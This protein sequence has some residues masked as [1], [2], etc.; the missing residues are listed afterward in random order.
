MNI[1][2]RFFGF[3]KLETNETKLTLLYR[4]MS[5]ECSNRC[6]FGDKCRNKRF[7]RKRYSKL[8]IFFAKEKGHGLRA[9]ENIPSGD[10]IIE[11]IGEVVSTREFTKRSHEYSK[12]KSKHHY[13][14]ELTRGA[15]IDA[16]QKGQISRFI[17][18]SCDPNCETQKWTVNGIIR[19]GFFAIRDIV[20]GEEITFD[21][22]FIHFG[23]GQKCLC[24]A[25]NCRGT[26]GREAAFNEYKKKAGLRD[27]DKD[28]D[29]SKEILG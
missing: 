26:I 22:Q 9:L 16:T 10:F 6:R 21:Y 17:N 28:V 4:I 8:E 25:T 2:F 1:S 12:A 19:V 3:L 29:Y 7:Q 18:H 20:A 24:G 23:K 15:T 5:I 27:D 11:Y 14:M 13:F